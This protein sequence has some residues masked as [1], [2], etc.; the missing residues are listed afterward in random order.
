VDLGVTHVGLWLEQTRDFG[1]ARAARAVRDA[2]MRVSTLCRG[3]FFQRDGWLDDNRRA[4]DDAATIGAPV[5]VLVSGGLPD[6]SRDI[7]GA[8]ARVADAIAELAPFA[9][10][11]GVQLAVEP[12]H[13]MFASDRCVI[14]TLAQALDLAEAHSA[15]V[16]GVV[17]DTYHVWWDDQV[18]RQIA[19]AGSRIAILQLSDWTTPLPAGVL[20]GRSMPGEGCIE[21]GRL[22]SAAASA[23]YAGPIEVEVFND[24]LCARPGA[25]ILSRTI[26][27]FR[28]VTDNLESAWTSMTS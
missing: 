7:D 6:G 8:R 22:A 16:V 20:N 25:E 10:A 3:G 24:E 4:V 26:A 15:G 14:S 5:L 11:A 21:L 13:P 9:A 19:R 18:Y 12:V 17:L 23:G 1:V 27:A 28:S 2:G